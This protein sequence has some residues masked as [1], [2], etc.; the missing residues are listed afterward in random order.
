MLV[1]DPERKKKADAPS[2][3]YVGGP[4]MGTSDTPATEWARRHRDAWTA[5]GGRE[6]YPA[7]DLFLIDDTTASSE[8]EE[9][10]EKTPAT[11]KR[12]LKA[13]D[14]RDVKRRRSG[15]A[16]G[17]AESPGTAWSDVHR[18]RW[19]SRPRSAVQPAA[20]ESSSSSS[21]SSSDEE[22][23]PPSESDDDDDDDDD[24]GGEYKVGDQLPKTV[25]SFRT[26]SA[27]K[28]VTYNVSSSS[29][30]A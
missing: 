17:T 30:L 4:V 18:S 26:R 5:I 21:S 14:V 24:D 10:E 1:N 25:L 23:P 12:K 16:T 8:E 13:Q 29:S 6:K 20:D 11:R 27:A 19:L 22:V 9:D 15:V 7:G 28:K 2:G 3:P